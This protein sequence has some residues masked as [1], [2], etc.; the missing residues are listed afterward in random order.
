MTRVSIVI[1]TYNRLTRLKQVIAAVERQTY[2]LEDIEVIVVSD[3][4]TDGTNE[5]LATIQTSLNLRFVPQENAG[6][7]AARNNG[8]RNAGSEYVLFIDDDVVPSPQLVA[9]HMRQHVA[10]PNLVVLGPMLNPPDF[11]HEPWVAWEQAMLGKQYT[12]MSHGNWTATARQFYT[13]NTSLP[14]QVL[15]SSGGFDERFRR[16]EDIELAYRIEKLGVEFCFTMDAV[17][18]HYAERSFVSWLQIPYTYGRYEIVFSRE[19]QHQLLDFVQE[20][21]ETR[22]WLT[23]MVVGVCL[24]RPKISGAVQAIAK[25][26]ADI[27]YRGGARGRQIAQAAYSAIFNLRYYQGVSDELGGRKAFF[28]ST[29]VRTLSKPASS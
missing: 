20:Q 2:P 9:E 19:V 15:I 16:A 8:F 10:R 7:A 12:A 29:K 14:R 21:F 1:P 5:Y 3:G 22:N 13:G 18:Y 23:R 17:G 26:I 6:P 24:D 4:S 27:S 28:G 25:R 11:T